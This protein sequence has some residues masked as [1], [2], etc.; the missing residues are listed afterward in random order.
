MLKYVR[1]VKHSVKGAADGNEVG[2]EL[3]RVV[4]V[5]AKD[6][7]MDLSELSSRFLAVEQPEN[8]PLNLSVPSLHMK[9]KKKQQHS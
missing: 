3:V 2:D 9:K 1:C 4:K 5:V 8:P 7:C 6:V